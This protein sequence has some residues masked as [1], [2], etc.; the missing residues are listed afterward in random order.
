[1][2]PTLALV[3]A[4]CT[5]SPVLKQRSIDQQ[6]SFDKATLLAL[7]EPSFDQDLANGGGGWRGLASK[8]GCELVAANLIA[9]YRSAHN[10]DSHILFW[11][12]GQ[13]RAFSGQSAQAIS[14]FEKAYKPAQ[15]DFGWNAYVAATIAFLRSDRQAL[16]QALIILKSTPA[17]PGETLKHGQLE[18][19]LSD[20]T[21]TAVPWP[22]NVDVVEGLQRCAG[23]T[24]REAYS[25]ACRIG[26]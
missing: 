9:E 15:Q 19:T 2:L 6:C 8:Q 11:H 26:N 20:G 3:L 5:G 22:P 21:R 25:S 4:S 14:L 18:V 24:Y 13:L 12:E 1:M 7:D 23:K 10:L 17:P 16:D